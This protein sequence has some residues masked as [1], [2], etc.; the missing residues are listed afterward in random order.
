MEIVC[1]INCNTVN[2]IFFNTTRKVKYKANE[3]SVPVV[4]T[5]DTDSLNLMLLFFPLEFLH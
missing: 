4:L 3:C 2:I 5:D 1:V